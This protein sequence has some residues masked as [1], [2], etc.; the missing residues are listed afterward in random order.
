MNNQERRSLID[1][2]NYNL[3]HCFC[4]E[5]TKRLMQIALTHLSNEM[6]PSPVAE[7][8]PIAWLNDAYLARGV[9][10]GEAGSEDAGP[11]YIPVYRE[12]GPQPLP[13][14]PDIDELRLAFEAAERESD[15]GFNLHKY[16]IG[17]ADDETQGRW[18]SWLACRAAMLQDGNSP[19]IPDTW[20]PVSERMPEMGEKQRYVLAADF[21]N[22]YWP[23]IPNTQVGVYGDWFDDGNPTWDD[24]DG[25]DLH[26]KEVTH[27][28]PLPAAPQDAHDDINALIPL[29]SRNEQEVK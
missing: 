7:R 23:N 29:V 6:Q 12:A 26:L 3:Q 28:M 10:D 16:G 9:V 11:G 27:W 21:K 13:V 2:A 8:E 24:G 5:K 22:N 19:V 4:T 18:E 1:E 20:I 14:V 17:Y 25:E 15:D